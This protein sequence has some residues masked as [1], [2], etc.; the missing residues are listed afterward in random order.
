MP[1]VWFVEESQW[2]AML[3]SE[4]PVDVGAEVPRAV[5][6]E[7][8]SSGTKQVPIQKATRIVPVK[9]GSS[10]MS[11]LIWGAEETVRVNGWALTTGLRVLADKDEIR[12]GD[13]ASL[14]Y[15]SESVAEI[16]TF[17]GSDREIFCPRCTLVIQK[18]QSVVR[19]PC[20]QLIHHQDAELGCWVYAPGCASCSHPTA[21]DAGFR[22]APDEPWA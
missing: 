18:G 13:R 20:C 14:F 15:S 8:A 3:L 10:Q 17:P 7:H 2:T 9:N 21:L 19:C 16:E 11:L 6:A 22:W 12:I 5:A 1:Y 4:M